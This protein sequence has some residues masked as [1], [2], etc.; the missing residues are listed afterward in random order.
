MHLP[1]FAHLE[2]AG[3]SFPREI[4]DMLE[5]TVDHLISASSVHGTVVTPVGKIMHAKGHVARQPQRE[6]CPILS[7][8]RGETEAYKKK[9]LT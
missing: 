1:G 6:F 4:G 3:W 8:R 7:S 2:K 9:G 5:S